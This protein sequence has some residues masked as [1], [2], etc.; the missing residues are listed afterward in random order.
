[1]CPAQPVSINQHFHESVNRGGLQPP[2]MTVGI[3]HLD[4]L[5]ATAIGEEDLYGI[6]DVNALDVVQAIFDPLVQSQRRLYPL[7]H[8]KYALRQ[9]RLCSGHASCRSD[10]IIA[11]DRPNKKIKELMMNRNKYINVCKT[12]MTGENAFV[13]NT[14][15]GEKGMVESCT[16]DHLLVKT[17]EGKERCWDFHRCEESTRS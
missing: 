12:T 16:H 6:G 11:M 17:S 14:V 1:M 15:S 4:Q 10:K 8:R 3:L 13:C 9:K 2:A 5:G 7:H